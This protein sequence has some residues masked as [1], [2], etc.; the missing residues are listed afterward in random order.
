MVAASP[1]CPP[2]AGVGQVQLQHRISTQL[3]GVFKA[4]D[5]VAGFLLSEVDI[6]GQIEIP[7]ILRV[8]VEQRLQRFACLVK[9]IAFHRQQSATILGGMLLADIAFI[10]GVQQIGAQLVV[11]VGVHP[12]GTRLRQI[13]VRRGLYHHR[14]HLVGAVTGIG[15]SAF[16]QGVGEQHFRR[17]VE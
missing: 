11:A 6:G 1:G 2:A 8:G 9:V 17:R 5:G 15:Q 10:P 12:E 4:I 13:E 7:G 14:A 3:A 16:R